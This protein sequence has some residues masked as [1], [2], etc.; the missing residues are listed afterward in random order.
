[1]P[2]VP[3]SPGPQ[4][5]DAPLQGG[6][7]ATPDTG[8]SAR[9]LAGGFDKVM[10]VADKFVQRDDMDVAW[11][12]DAKIKTDAAVFTS[13][14]QQRMR[15]AAVKGAVDPETGNATGSYAQQV[16]AWWAAAGPKYAAGL[17]GYTIRLGNA[18]LFGGTSGVRTGQ[19]LHLLS[20]RRP[21]TYCQRA[22]P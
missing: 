12:T 7:Q 21:S 15:G 19:R 14:L 17:S 4:V 3:I 9:A 5:Q 22:R 6:F 20:T 1:M 16:A 13:Q 18:V 8:A 11:A 10:D 2:Q